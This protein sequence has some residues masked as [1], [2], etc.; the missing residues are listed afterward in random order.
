MS[1]RALAQLALA[2]V[3]CGC[4]ANGVDRTWGYTPVGAF[5]ISRCRGFC[6]ARVDVGSGSEKCL[7][8]AEKM[9]QICLPAKD[10]VV[11]RGT[12]Q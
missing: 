5:D 3:L 12:F 10:Q 8:F 6:V 1:K 9:A 11:P 4:A 2:S 7:Q